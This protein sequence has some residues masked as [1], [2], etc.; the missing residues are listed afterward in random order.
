MLYPLI[1]A[2]NF[3]TEQVTFA[4]MIPLFVAMAVVLCGRILPEVG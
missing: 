3:A 1:I 4:L 2:M